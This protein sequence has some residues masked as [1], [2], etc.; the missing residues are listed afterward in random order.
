MKHPLVSVIIPTYNRTDYLEITL[1]SV[2]SQTYTNIEIIVVDDG[3]DGNANKALCDLFSNVIYIRIKNSGG[4]ARP[5]NKGIEMAKGELLA[6]TDDDDIWLPQKLE[7][8]VSVLTN[9][10]NYGLVHCPCVV[11]DEF[12]NKTTEII[13]RPGSPLVKHGDVKFRM[14]GNWTLMM[15]TPLVRREV[16][17]KVGFFNEKIPPALEDV[18]FW[19]R[20]SFYTS[21]YYMDEPMVLYRKHTNNISSDKKKYIQLPLYL[22]KVISKQMEEGRINRKEGRLL[23]VSLC[24]MQAKMIKYNFLKTLFNLFKLNPFWFL[25]FNHSKTLVKMLIS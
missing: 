11:I 6:F 12:G 25:N 5:R 17:K 4:P 22:S 21:F 24:Q 16:I 8:Q 14:M 23:H 9:N 15:P 1:K 13:G 18:E 2:I 19:V 10:S 20:C 3:S 7:A